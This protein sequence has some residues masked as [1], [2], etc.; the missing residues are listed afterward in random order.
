MAQEDSDD[1]DDQETMHKGDIAEKYLRLFASTSCTDKIFWLRDKN[2]KFFIAN[3]E[4]RIK[5]NN[6]IVGGR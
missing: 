3:K 6:L 2:G 4:T 1:D 5:E